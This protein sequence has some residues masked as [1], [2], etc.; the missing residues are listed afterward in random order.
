MMIATGNGT[1]AIALQD[2]GNDIVEVGI[3]SDARNRRFWKN[4]ISRRWSS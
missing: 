4:S 2:S 3:G 1:N